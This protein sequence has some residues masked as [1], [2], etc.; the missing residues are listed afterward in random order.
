L[1]GGYQKNMFSN[2]KEKLTSINKKSEINIIAI[3]GS[4]TI[5]QCMNITIGK[6]EPDI[7]HDI[8]PMPWFRMLAQYLQSAYNIAVVIPPGE[9]VFTLPKACILSTSVTFN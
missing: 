8:I 7:H 3:G 4:I 1:N 2:L 9:V 6:S 5:G